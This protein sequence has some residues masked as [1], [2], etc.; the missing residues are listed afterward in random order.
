MR[1]HVTRGARVAILVPDTTN[2]IRFFQNDEIVA[3]ALF[4]VHAQPDTAEAGPNNDNAHRHWTIG[5]HANL[6]ALLRCGLSISIVVTL[7][8]ERFYLR[9]GGSQ[10]GV[11]TAGGRDANS[12]HGASTERPLR[13]QFTS[14][15]RLCKRRLSFGL[16]IHGSQ[17]NSA[18]V[19]RAR[20]M[21]A[22]S[23]FDILAVSGFS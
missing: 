8:R 14:I 15:F 2:G 1:R 22:N 6:K 19:S 21:A 11:C 13:H 10:R 7:K 9:M 12:S 18:S 4:K 3:A 17:V 23:S 16:C 20:N 5:R